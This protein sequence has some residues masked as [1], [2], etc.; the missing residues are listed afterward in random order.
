L[1]LTALSCLQDVA[2]DIEQVACNLYNVDEIEKKL[3]LIEVGTMREV[4]MRNISAFD[5]WVQKAIF[6]RF[7]IIFLDEISIQL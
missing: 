5:F 4:Y 3:V 1:L 6:Q 2:Q 7:S